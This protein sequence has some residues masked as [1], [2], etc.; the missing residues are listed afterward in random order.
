MTETKVHITFC[1]ALCKY[2]KKAKYFD[3]NI[4]IK[5]HNTISKDGICIYFEEVKYDKK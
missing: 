5:T 3:S 4:C 2:S 1:N